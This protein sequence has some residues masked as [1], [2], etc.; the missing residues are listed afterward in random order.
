MTI[1]C[2]EKCKTTVMVV[3]FA[4]TSIRAVK[5]HK[6][7]L[8]EKHKALRLSEDIMEMFCILNLYWS[9]LS[10]HL[11][12]QLIEELNLEERAF[13][14]VAAEMAVYVKDLHKFMGEM[15]LDLYCQAEPYTSEDPPPEFRKLV[16]RFDWPQTATL[17]DVENFRI[18]Y[19]RCYDLQTCAMMLNSIGT[20]SF[21]VT[22]F[23]PTAVVKLLMEER[24]LT[25][26]EDFSV[27]K[28]EIHTMT[29]ICVYE[30]K[31][32]SC[33]LS[34]VLTCYHSPISGGFTL[35]Q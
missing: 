2:L 3:L 9:Y 22:W 7:F 23:I 16:V 13:D 18:R 31:Q 6:V 15:T 32:V 10:Y 28:L 12:E 33:G 14:A 34:F 30:P 24:A 19:A 8:D 17:Q 26:F 1:R 5:E 20:G 21:T 27:T 4:L 11:L 35:C 25:V 29:E